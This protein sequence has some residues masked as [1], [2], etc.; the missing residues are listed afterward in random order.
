LQLQRNGRRPGFTSVRTR[1][2]VGSGFIGTSR[3]SQ[4][5][6]GMPAWRRATPPAAND[7]TPAT[8]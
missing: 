1:D 2:P 5:A 6:V 8:A 7:F 3:I 4:S